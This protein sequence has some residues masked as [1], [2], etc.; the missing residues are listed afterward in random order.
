MKVVLIALNAFRLLMGVEIAQENA[1]CT[2][3]STGA[4]VPSG[5]LL[6]T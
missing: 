3:H 2:P 4:F 5:E 6:T 1:E